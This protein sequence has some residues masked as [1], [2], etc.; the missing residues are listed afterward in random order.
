V[1]SSPPDRDVRQNAGYRLKAELFK[2]M[3]H[4][5]RLRL[6]E[7]LGTAE[8]TVSDLQAELALDSSTASQH[9]A[10]LRRQGLLAGRKAGTSVYY[11]IADVRTLELLAIAQRILLT[12]V[13]VSR[14][15]LDEL[16]RGDGQSTSTSPGVRRSAAV[17]PR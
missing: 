6:L 11:R 4:P 3:G 15:A 9:L 10:T 5:V 1:E 2:A 13:Q 8:R 14:D 17:R 12:N 16:G 7:A